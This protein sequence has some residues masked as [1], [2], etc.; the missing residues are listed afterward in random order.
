MLVLRQRNRQGRREEGAGGGGKSHRFDQV[1]PTK[2]GVDF[3]CTITI[4]GTKYDLASWANAHPGGAV[5]LRK[6]HNRDATNAFAR[7][8]HSQYAIDLLKKFQADGKGGSTNGTSKGTAP[9]GTTDRSVAA[10]PTPAAWRTKLFTHEDPQNLHKGCGLFVLLHYVSRFYQMLFGDVSAGFGNRTGMGPSA[11]CMLF[12]VPHAALS[13]SSLIFRTVPKERIVGAPMI[14]QEFRAHSIIF[15]SRSIVGSACS[16]IS[17]YFD[18]NPI[19]RNAVVFVNSICILCA[20]YAADAA[21]ERLRVCNRESTTA[22]MPYWEGC[23]LTTQRRFKQFYA[24][25]QFMAT[26]ACLSMANPCWSFSVL[27][28]IQLAAFLMTMVRKG[29]I[30][31]KAY[32]VVYTISLVLPYFVAVRSMFYSQTPD[33]LGL[34]VLGYLLYSLRCQGVGKYTLWVPVVLLRILIG[35]RLLTYD[36]W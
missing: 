8:G 7:I 17:V 31:T 34:F 24:Y 29:I 19:V 15:A 28:A 23:S 27:L 16:W 22:T 36:I 21:T 35:D 9:N 2:A 30:S 11:W 25:C 13:L 33:A 32:H 4:S 10:S 6:F 26:L 3:E 14:W 18:H 5:I 12:L 1:A 20:L